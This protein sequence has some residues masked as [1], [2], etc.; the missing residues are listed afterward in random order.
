MNIIV[1]NDDVVHA[2]QTTQRPSLLLPVRLAALVSLALAAHGSQ[3]QSGLTLLPRPALGITAEGVDLSLLWQADTP[4]GHPLNLVAGRNLLP[5]RST[6]FTQVPLSLGG[7]TEFPARRFSAQE[8]GYIGL[9]FKDGT[10]LTL[11][12]QSG[13][14]GLSYRATF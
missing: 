1:T 8:F 3:A 12:R 10:R 6:P 7:S 5:P 4:E 9:Q 2:M 14:L 13:G 11:R